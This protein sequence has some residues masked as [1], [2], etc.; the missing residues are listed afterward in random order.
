MFAMSV[1]EKIDDDGIS[2]L[3]MNIIKTKD[4]SKGMILRCFPA[5]GCIGVKGMTP[6]SQM[7][8]R[9]SDEHSFA[10]RVLRLRQN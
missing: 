3:N 8:N 4:A 10:C 1:K 9:E 5:N 2:E 7:T 6:T